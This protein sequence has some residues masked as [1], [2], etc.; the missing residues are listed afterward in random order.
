LILSILQQLKPPASYP[1]L[2]VGYH[3]DERVDPC[4]LP[5]SGLVLC[6][7][8]CPAAFR[9]KGAPARLLES[10][11]GIGLYKSPDALAI[12]RNPL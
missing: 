7:G 10:A 11:R 9:A 5:A 1:G 3:L 12:N 6:G 2:F 8:R 4:H